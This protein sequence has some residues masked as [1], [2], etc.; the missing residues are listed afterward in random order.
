MG[1]ILLLGIISSSLLADCFLV[2][3]VVN[4]GGVVP[5]S[6]FDGLLEIKEDNVFHSKEDVRGVVSSS[7]LCISDVVSSAAFNDCGVVLLTGGILSILY[8]VGC[9]STAG[10]ELADVIG[11]VGHIVVDVGGLSVIGLTVKSLS[12]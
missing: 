5:I 2:V 11:V 7:F 10:S 6:S 9:V 3:F 8:V 1:S 4:D 12:S